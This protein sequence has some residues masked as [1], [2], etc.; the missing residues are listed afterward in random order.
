[1]KITTLLLISASMAMSAPAFAADESYEATT[2][3]KKDS[4]GN[5]SQKDSV[6]KTDAAGTTTN[7]DKKA[8]VDVDSNGDVEKS[9]TTKKSVDP[10]GLFN[11]KTV[12]TSNKESSKNGIVK[13]SQKVTVNGTTVK[14]ESETSEQ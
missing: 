13:S 3:I 6:S 5:Y 7:F 8:S 1:M 2:K 11:K 14:D 9:T 4:D 12:K 10:K